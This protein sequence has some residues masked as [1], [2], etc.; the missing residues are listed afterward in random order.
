MALFR[1]S[2]DCLSLSEDVS[3]ETK[4][5]WLSLPE[6]IIFRFFDP[7]WIV[8]MRM[9]CKG[10]L[11]MMQRVKPDAW[12]TTK[13]YCD[14]RIVARLHML[15]VHCKIVTFKVYPG[16]LL[17][18]GGTSQMFEFFRLNGCLQN[19]VLWSL[20][21]QQEAGA[22]LG[23]LMQ[24]STLTRLV[25]GGGGP[26]RAETVQQIAGSLGNNCQLKE[27]RL[28]NCAMEF[29]GVRPLRDA[30]VLM[31]TLRT[32]SLES[33]SL[34]SLG[35]MVMADTLLNTTLENLSLAGNNIRY[36]RL[37]ARRLCDSYL[38]NLDLS[39]NMIDI[40]SIRV[41]ADALPLT[42]RLQDLN[43][44]ECDITQTGAQ[45]MAAALLGNS[46]LTVLSLRANRIR[47]MGAR[48][49]FTSLTGLTGNTTLTRL[50]VSHNEVGR[51]MRRRLNTLSY[52]KTKFTII[53]S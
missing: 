35:C 25:S 40:K 33:N 13:A 23:E 34:G 2:V 3:S 46:S 15:S 50:D 37:L 14:D 36:L 30:V 1:E 44:S 41:L 21:L 11:E 5:D 24:L 31:T 49:L 29:E 32:L 28:D 53:T 18:V 22:A 20:D 52:I 47:A 9:I 8:V 12:V 10:W 43:L 27:L 16:H 19:L 39:G 26:L 45:M 38:I 7:R 51:Y 42:T 4:V 48:D 17:T 6:E